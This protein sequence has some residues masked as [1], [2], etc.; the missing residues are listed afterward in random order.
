L[1]A[2]HQDQKEAMMPSQNG[3]SFTRRGFFGVAGGVSVAAILAACSPSGAG[4]GGGG[5][6]SKPLK[7]WNMPWGGTKFNPTDKKITLAYKPKKGL[8]A[9]T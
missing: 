3:A 1:D 2:A 6:S 4:G 9:A 8:P 7:F 5:G